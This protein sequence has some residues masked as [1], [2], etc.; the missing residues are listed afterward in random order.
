MY[1]YVSVKIK[2]YGNIISLPDTDYSQLNKNGI[3]IVLRR[4]TRSAMINK[5]KIIEN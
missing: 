5:T 1:G 4:Y 3:S 2:G